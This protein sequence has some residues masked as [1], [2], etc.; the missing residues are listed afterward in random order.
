MAR[1]GK[2]DAYA[3]DGFRYDMG[4]PKGYLK[5]VIDFALR[6]NELGEYLRNEK[7]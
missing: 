7:F 1:D 2:V 5:A 4:N 3:H 6:D